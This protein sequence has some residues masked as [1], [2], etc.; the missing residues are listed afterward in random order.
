MRHLTETGK[1][2]Y[3][4]LET[5]VKGKL[6]MAEVD[7]IELSMLANSYDLYFRM[8]KYCNDHGVT[9]SFSKKVAEA[10]VGTELAEDEADEI[11]AKT[12]GAYQQ[13]RPEYTAMKN[14]YQNILKHSS[15]FG[16]TP[17]DRAKIFKDFGKKDE[18][19]PMVEL[20]NQR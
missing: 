11:K 13:I 15:K 19:D 6:A 10:N 4:R 5:F 20:N 12:G 7:D 18:V 9:M 3:T 17:G 1:A 14:E 8:A 16:L 2:I